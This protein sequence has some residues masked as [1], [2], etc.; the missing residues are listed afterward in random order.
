LKPVCHPPWREHRTLA[1]GK[2]RQEPL[3]AIALNPGPQAGREFLKA[4]FNQVGSNPQAF[5]IG[6]CVK[7]GRI[8]AARPK[9]VQCRDAGRDI[10]NAE[11][12]HD[13]I[14]NAMSLPAIFS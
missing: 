7:A 13:Q 11:A 6:R 4:V 8:A 1:P 2:Y 9:L 10:Q 12:N 3:E 14:L 5:G